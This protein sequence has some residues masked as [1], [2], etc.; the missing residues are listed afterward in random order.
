[1]SATTISPSVDSQVAVSLAAL[2]TLAG[3]PRPS[4]PTDPS[5]TL[6]VSR[7]EIILT[8]ERADVRLYPADTTTPL[9][10]NH[11]YRARVAD[12]LAGHHAPTVTYTDHGAGETP[13]ARPWPFPNGGADAAGKLSAG[14]W[15]TLARIGAVADA[16]P[17][18]VGLGDYRRR[19]HLES[20]LLTLGQRAGQTGMVAAAC[21]GFALLVAHEVGRAY[22]APTIPRSFQLPADIVR[23][24]ARLKVDGAL[25]PRADGRLL[26]ALSRGDRLIGHL[27]IDVEPRAWPDWRQLIPRDCPDESHRQRADLLAEA[28][29]ALA[30]KRSQDADRRTLYTWTAESALLVNGVPHNPASVESVLNAMTTP[31]VRVASAGPSKPTLWT[32]GQITAVLMPV[33]LKGVN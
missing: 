5:G 20:V 18:N 23:A 10:F 28:A 24:V 15:R 9:A 13:G 22:H 17:T 4:N 27:V 3:R 33:L 26:V 31:A 14:D 19:P 21:D 8:L 11:P 2:K 29:R 6:L 32:A 25:Y 7:S 16:R 1:M 30:V 12:Y